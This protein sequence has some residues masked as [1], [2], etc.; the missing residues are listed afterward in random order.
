ME[1]GVAISVLFNPIKRA[2]SKQLHTASSTLF[3]ERSD[4]SA[5]AMIRSAFFIKTPYL[6]PTPKEITHTAGARS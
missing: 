2:I 4:K 5:I 1:V 3:A 6:L